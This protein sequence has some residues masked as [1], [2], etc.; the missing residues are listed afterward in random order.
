MKRRSSCTAPASVRSGRWS[1]PRSASAQPPTSSGPPTWAGWKARNAGRPPYVRYPLA[2]L[3]GSLEW[4]PSRLCGLA[5]FKLLEPAAVLVLAFF[6]LT[7]MDD[8]TKERHYRAWELINS[9]RATGSADKT[10]VGWSGDGGRREALQDLH[11]HGVSLAGAL[12]EGA[13]LPGIDLRGADLRA[14]DFAGA[15]LEGANLKGAKL[16]NATLAGAS[17]R[18]AM[19][20]GAELFG[21]DLQGANLAEANLQRARL[22]SDFP[23]NVESAY[24]HPS[25][26]LQGANLSVCPRRC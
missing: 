7:E 12:L 20:Q 17:L 3:W 19:L 5:L 16:H 21:A 23:G 4:A 18:G 9:A 22:D 2:L 11:S 13:H 10:Q 8:R 15:N 1:Q 14:A 25:W 26:K 6:W 24:L